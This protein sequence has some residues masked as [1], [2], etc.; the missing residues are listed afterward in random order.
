MDRGKRGSGSIVVWKYIFA[1]CIIIYTALVFVYMSG[2]NRPFKEVKQAVERKIDTERMKDVSSQGLKRYYG[3][4]GA[5]YDGVM[6]YVSTS[7]MSAEEVLVVKAK[8]TEQAR[9][10]ENAIEKRIEERKNVFDGY[11]PEQVKML[12]EAQKSVRGTYVF[13][14]I[15]PDSNRYREAF[16]KAL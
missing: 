10:L 1:G 9:E 14:A 12:K 15:S 4:N 2:S 16:T 13:L 11:A 6:M 5:D 7:S 3:L 8:N